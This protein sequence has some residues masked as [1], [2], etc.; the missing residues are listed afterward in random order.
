MRPCLDHPE[1]WHAIAFGL[2]SP[3]LKT[4]HD[5][6]AAERPF[7]VFLLLFKLL[8]IGTIVKYIALTMLIISI[9]ACSQETAFKEYGFACD[10]AQAEALGA[11][12]A[13]ESKKQG[14]QHDAHDHANHTANIITIW[15]EPNRVAHQYQ[16]PAITLAWT[17]D[18]LGHFYHWKFFDNEQRA[19]EYEPVEIADDVRHNR[20]TEKNQLVSNELKNAMHKQG[21]SGNGCNLVEFYSLNIN[22]TQF[23]L[24]WL[25][26]LGIPAEFDVVRGTQHEH[27]HLEELIADKQQVSRAFSTRYAY[28]STDFADIGDNETDPF[29]INMMNL[30]FIQHG[31]SGFYD[32]QGNAMGDGHKH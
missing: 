31:A 12:Y 17:K 8:P 19:I 3:G 25:A 21:S 27:W 4:E 22:E 32:A 2:F 5:R 15:R 9:A 1:K 16:N 10:N 23:K 18:T 20:W 29:F 11:V 13:F 30:G 7:F 6:G 24:A 28:Q 26:K 14:Q